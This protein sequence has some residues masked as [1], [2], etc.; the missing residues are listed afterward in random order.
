[1]Y[2]H[3]GIFKNPM[4]FWELKLK[5]HSIA[6]D[7]DVL[8]SF[9]D[10]F[11]SIGE[12][13]GVFV[14]NQT[15]DGYKRNYHGN[16]LD[17]LKK[18]Y[19]RREPV[20]LFNHLAHSNSIDCP[21]LLFYETDTGIQQNWV[22]DIS[23]LQ[24]DISNKT[25]KKIEISESTSPLIIQGS[26]HPIIR[27]EKPLNNSIYISICIKTDIWFPKVCDVNNISISSPWHFRYIDEY[28]QMIDNKELASLHTP[29]LNNA[30]K[31]I[32]TLADE[33]GEWSVYTDEIYEMYRPMLNADGTIIL[34]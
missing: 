17:Y 21:S 30:I 3:W 32:L 28:E 24:R 15:L 6:E 14:I 8:C 29:N 23:I 5:N 11:L 19:I 7:F 12:S 9:M 2:F 34:D 20:V 26:A 16:Y 27:G 18:R 22:K 25:K 13:E 31:S 1:M 33:Y 10:R 4:V